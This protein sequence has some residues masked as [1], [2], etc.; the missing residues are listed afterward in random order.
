MGGKTKGNILVV[1][2]N[3]AQRTFAAAL[4]AAE[5]YWVAEA[6]DAWQAFSLCESLGRPLH[7][8]AA[9]VGPGRDQGGVE[10]YRHLHVLR[11]ELKALYLAS[12]PADPSL[13]LE[14]ETALD[15]YLSKPFTREALLDKVE[16]LLSKGR[17]EV[18]QLSARRRT[19]WLPAEEPAP[20]A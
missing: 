2:R 12:V 8:L 18:R 5:G 9:E 19:D 1:E 4:L 15:S 16:R 13:R 11:P 3:P 10:L 6:E 14:L 17:G 20:G 7:L